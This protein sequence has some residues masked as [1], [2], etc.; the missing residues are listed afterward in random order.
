MKKE[1]LRT[2]TKDVENLAAKIAGLTL[3]LQLG[4]NICYEANKDDVAEATSLLGD[5]C[6]RLENEA[7][8][9]WEV[10]TKEEQKLCRK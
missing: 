3:V 8:R 4:T 2:I 10:L 5:A 7:Y 6:K 1:Q 9:I